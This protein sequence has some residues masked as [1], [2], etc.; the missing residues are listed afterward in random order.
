MGY[1]SAARPDGMCVGGRVVGEFVMEQE[2]R[3]GGF[4]RESDTVDAR[5]RD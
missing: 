4:K 5:I 1:T 3:S 2:S